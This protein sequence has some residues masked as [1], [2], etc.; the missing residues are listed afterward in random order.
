MI[1]AVVVE[2]RPV[3]QVAREYGVSRRTS[4]APTQDLTEVGREPC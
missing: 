2:K 4:L 3:A 1:T